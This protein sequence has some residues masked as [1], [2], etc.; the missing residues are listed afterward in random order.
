MLN[1]LVANIKTHH[2]NVLYFLKRLLMLW[3]GKPLNVCDISPLD[4]I[5][6]YTIVTLLLEEDHF[7]TITLKAL[8]QK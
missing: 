3:M 7:F 4:V 6:I 8:Q 5:I 1:K 2:E